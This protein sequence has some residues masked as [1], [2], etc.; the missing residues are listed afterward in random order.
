ML[1]FVPYF[2]RIHRLLAKSRS[3]LFPVEITTFTITS[4]EQKSK[5]F[6]NFTFFYNFTSPCEN[7][8]TS[9]FKGRC[10][11]KTVNQIVF[12][13]KSSTHFSVTN[14]SLLSAQLK[15]KST[16]SEIF[17]DVWRSDNTYWVKC[18]VTR[19]KICIYLVKHYICFYNEVF[20]FLK[21]YVFPPPPP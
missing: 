4:E 9:N 21:K 6:L 20:C 11:W 1:S 5:N 16:F 17:C 14:I 2:F 13:V 10:R 7:L 19:Y 8:T 3:S 15:K 12:S 18:E